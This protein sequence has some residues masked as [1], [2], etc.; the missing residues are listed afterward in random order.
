M[1]APYNTHHP[2]LQLQP[3]PTPSF[4]QLPPPDLQPVSV[5][6]NGYNPC[7]AYQQQRQ[8]CPQYYHSSGCYYA[9]GQPM[10][11]LC[12]NMLSMLHHMHHCPVH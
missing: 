4:G 6:H 11:Q 1:P 5:R 2:Q 3:V 7:C 12:P 8:F 10:M 9:Q